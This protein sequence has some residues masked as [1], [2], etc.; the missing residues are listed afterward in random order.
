[1]FRLEKVAKR[2]KVETRGGPG[3]GVRPRVPGAP[4]AV[5]A[6][7]GAGPPARTSQ[8]W[9]WVLSFQ[10]KTRRRS[11]RIRKSEKRLPPV[12]LRLKRSPTDCF[13]RLTGSFNRTLLRVSERKSKRE[14]NRKRG[15]HGLPGGSADADAAVACGSAGPPARTS[16]GCDRAPKFA[17]SE[18]RH[19]SNLLRLKTSS[20]DC[21]QQLNGDFNRT[22]LRLSERKS[23]RKEHRKRERAPGAGCPERRNCAWERGPTSANVPGLQ[24]RNNPCF[25]GK[26]IY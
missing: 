4:C 10:T 8:G 12:L 20:T 26:L 16:K 24:S 13:Q 7:G 6:H 19:P 9:N 3:R 11:Q 22:M 2:T 14:E 17:K 25:T 21:F 15:E 18:K 5:V 23:K 1:M